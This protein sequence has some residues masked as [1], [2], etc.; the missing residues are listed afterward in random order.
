MI[1]LE[2]N[3]FPPPFLRSAWS[4]ELSYCRPSSHVCTLLCVLYQASRVDFKITNRI[5]SRSCSQPSMCPDRI[6]DSIQSFLVESDALWVMPVS[7]PHV[8]LLTPLLSS[9]TRLSLLL[10]HNEL[11]PAPGATPSPLLH[12]GNCFPWISHWILPSHNSQRCSGLAS[13]SLSS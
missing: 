7:G 2:V 9:I 10:K 13:A 6:H 5:S 12:T 1:R 3:R 8:L 4:H 11:T